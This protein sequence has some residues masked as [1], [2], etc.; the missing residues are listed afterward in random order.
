VK[1][2]CTYALILFLLD[3]HCS[4]HF[5]VVFLNKNYFALDCAAESQTYATASLFPE[6]LTY[7]KILG[8]KLFSQ[9][10]EK[11]HQEAFTSKEYLFL[12]LH[13]LSSTFFL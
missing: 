7:K 12:M 9:I 13:L 11:G 8:T 3:I 10:K 6:P 5:G 2:K 1:G 4:L